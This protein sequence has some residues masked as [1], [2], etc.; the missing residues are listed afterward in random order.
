MPQET[1]EI[2]A[3]ELLGQAIASYLRAADAGRPLDRAEFL[4]RHPELKDELST[5]FSNF[6]EAELLSRPLRDLST[7][8]QPLSGERFEDYEILGEVARGGMGVI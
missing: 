5:F 6:D 3:E 8:L 7:S 2:D 1:P 4:A